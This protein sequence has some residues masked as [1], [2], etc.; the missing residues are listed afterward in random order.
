[1]IVI[2]PTPG[3]FAV[4]VKVPVIPAIVNCEMV[5][6]LFSW[7]ESFVN[8]LPEAIASSWIFTVSFTTIGG[9][10]TGVT[11]ISSVPFV[12]PPFPSDTA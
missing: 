12:I 8:K 7:S 3:I 10:F 11:V 6:G 1:M 2:V 9:S 4:E 5:K